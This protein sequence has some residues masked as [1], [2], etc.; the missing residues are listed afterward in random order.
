MAAF[1]IDTGFACS[2]NGD[3]YSNHLFQQMC[4]WYGW[5]RGWDQKWKRPFILCFLNACP[6]C[7]ANRRGKHGNLIIYIRSLAWQKSLCCLRMVFIWSLHRAVFGDRAFSGKCTCWFPVSACV[8]RQFLQNVGT[9]H[10]SRVG[11]IHGAD[12]I[13]AP[14]H[15]VCPN[16]YQ[17]GLFWL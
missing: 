4:A 14:D 9:Y 15:K 1:F 5:Q 3:F 17:L 13:L 2:K 7:E 12:I 6:V 11:N 10:K 16:V 8:S